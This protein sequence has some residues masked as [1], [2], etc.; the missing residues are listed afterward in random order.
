MTPQLNQIDN[1]QHASTLHVT[2]KSD[3]SLLLWL[4]FHQSQ[5]CQ[6]NFSG[7]CRTR[8]T[9]GLPWRPRSCGSGWV[10]D[11][12]GE[13]IVYKSS[14]TYETRKSCVCPWDAL[15]CV[16]SKQNTFER[17]RAFLATNTSFRLLKNSCHHV[18]P[19]IFPMKLH[20]M[21]FWKTITE[22]VSS[23]PCNILRA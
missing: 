14:W 21:K 11:I 20:S 22:T 10:I 15:I 12:I 9:W 1:L 6:V 23:L 16:N 13:C 19:E 7:T 18:K 4:K 8:G 3:L 2:T 5:S 17:E